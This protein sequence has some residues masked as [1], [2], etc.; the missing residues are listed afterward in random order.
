MVIDKIKPR[1]GWKRFYADTLKVYNAG[2]GAILGRV[3]GVVNLA[4]LASTYLLVKGFELSFTESILV[5][6][7][8]IAFIMVSGFV[9]LQQGLTKAEFSSGF[10]EQP[11]M[12]QM[13]RD[14][15]EIKRIL[16]EQEK[17]GVVK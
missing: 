3:S 4:L 15:E 1:T 9:Y 14:I 7:A 10:E 12:K 16:L 5:G 11:E 8:F 2:Y 17:R 13:K 6:V